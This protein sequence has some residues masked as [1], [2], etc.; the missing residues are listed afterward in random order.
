[1]ARSIRD[2]NAPTVSKCRNPGNNIHIYNVTSSWYWVSTRVFN[3]R[4][5][6]GEWDMI[7]A[8]GSP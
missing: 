4:L 1:M 7:M 8:Q 3:I 2:Q 5:S 6:I